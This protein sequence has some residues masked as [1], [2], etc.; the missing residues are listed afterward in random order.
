LQVCS[1]EVRWNQFASDLK[2]LGYDAGSDPGPGAI[3]AFNNSPEAVTL[4]TEAIPR[5]KLVHLAVIATISWIVL[6]FALMV[7]LRDTRA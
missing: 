2:A 4:M 5:K 7:V 6:I 3:V 1:P